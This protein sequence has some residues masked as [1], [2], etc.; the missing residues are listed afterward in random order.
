MLL[1]WQL[2]MLVKKAQDH[3]V[4]TLEVEV[5]GSRLRSRERSARFGSIGFEHHI[6]S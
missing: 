1:K 2:K 6:Y 4:K 3:G 5:Q